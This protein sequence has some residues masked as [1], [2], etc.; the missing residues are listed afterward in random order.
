MSFIAS[1][2]LLVNNLGASVVLAVLS[3]VGDGVVHEVD[4]GFVHQ[5]DDHLHLV[6]ALEICQLGRG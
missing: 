1:A 5:V 3:S 6:I 2:G 4:A